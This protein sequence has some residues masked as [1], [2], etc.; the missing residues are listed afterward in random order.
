L[1]AS[2]L[3]PVDNPDLVSQT[4]EFLLTYEKAR[5]VL[6]TGRYEDRL[7][8]SLR[9]SGRRTSAGRILRDLATDHR[10]AGGHGAIAGGSFYVGK[11]APEET[12]AAIEEDLQRRLARRL[13]IPSRGGFRRVFSE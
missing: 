13:R 7:H 4:A 2:H 10:D 8:L 12:W 9:T 5:W 3:G 11:R 6:C 1:L